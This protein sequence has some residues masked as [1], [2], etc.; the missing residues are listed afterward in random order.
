[1]RVAASDAADARYAAEVNAARAAEASLATRD[2]AMREIADARADA[3]RTLGEARA[4][5]DATIEKANAVEAARN[6]AG[7]ARTR[8][9]RTIRTSRSRR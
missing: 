5:Y 6:E 7:S 1:L 9:P 2:F 3:L 4:A 8:P